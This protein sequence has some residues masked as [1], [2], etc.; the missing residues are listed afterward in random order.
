MGDSHMALFNGGHPVQA[1]S[2]S[3]L[4]FLI[5]VVGMACE[6]RSVDTTPV[7]HSTASAPSRQLRPTAEELP[8]M[9]LE[10]SPVTQGSV[11]LH[12]VLPTNIN[13]N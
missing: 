7:A 12:R 11:I 5:L 8:R 1:C 9:Q 13:A 2:R 10:L 4:V 3:L 6:N